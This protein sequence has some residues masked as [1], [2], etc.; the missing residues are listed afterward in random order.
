MV[1]EENNNEK[2][3]TKKIELIEVHNCRSFGRWR[4]RILTGTDG[5]IE[6]P[7]KGM[8]EARIN[9]STA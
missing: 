1:M 3:T 9:L 6:P 7:L 4:N 8:L 5:E 2:I